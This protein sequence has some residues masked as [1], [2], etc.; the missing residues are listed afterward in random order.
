MADQ[1]DFDG[2]DHDAPDVPDSSPDTST[3]DVAEQSA[4]GSSPDT[5]VADSSSDGGDESHETLLSFVESVLDRAES[6]DSSGEEGEESG[7]RDDT[8]DEPVAADGSDDYDDLAGDNSKEANFERLRRE[9]AKLKKELEAATHEA[10]YARKIREYMQSQGLDGQEA[11]EA[12][13]FAAMVKSATQGGKDPREALA[14]IDK[15]RQHMAMLAGEAIPDDLRQ[16][17]D[18]G[19]VDEET[20]RQL[21]QYRSQL[22][23]QQRVQA[24]REAES[25]R[26]WQN[27]QLQRIGNTVKQWEANVAQSDPDYAT[28][29][30]FVLDRVRVLAAEYGAP[31][32]E[33]QAMQLAQ[34]A[35][36]EVSQ[37][38][39]ARQARPTVPSPSSHSGNGAASMPAP[40]SVLEAITRAAR[41]EH[42]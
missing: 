31:Q 15:L 22:E 13:N 36:N 9:R 5:D 34:Q 32:D 42:T 17:V 38:M 25:Q 21:A 10:G 16:K 26:F 23:M 12:L 14:E 29:R 11:V 18:D 27:Q 33:N 3:P 6:D 41:G 40:K 30:R 39:P 2:V 7:D 8:G 28:K 35:Y 1:E 37:S 19:Y 20:A 4:E 24:N